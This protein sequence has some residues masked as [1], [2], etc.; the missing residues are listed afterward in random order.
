MWE[1]PRE[2]AKLPREKLQCEETMRA[3]DS[4][5]LLAGWKRSLQ[6]IQA[7]F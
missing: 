5:H 1:K 2:K 7:D 3:W 4:A 6:E